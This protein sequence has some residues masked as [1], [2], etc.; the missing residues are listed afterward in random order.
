M[1]KVSIF[2]YF[3]RQ[4]TH[5]GAFSSQMHTRFKLLY[6]QNDWSNSNQFLHSDKDHQLLFVATSQSLSHRSKMADGKVT[7]RL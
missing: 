7:D 3:Y 5:K 2:P 6:Y 1:Q 4:N